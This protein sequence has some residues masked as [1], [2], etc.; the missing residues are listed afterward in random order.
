MK[1]NKIRVTFFSLLFILSI[2]S[3][4]YLNLHVGNDQD[5]S[6]VEVQDTPTEP[7]EELMADIDAFKTLIQKVA[8]Q[9]KFQ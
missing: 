7:S 9:I 1:S 8:R 6:L 5:Q 4:L 2:S 3:S